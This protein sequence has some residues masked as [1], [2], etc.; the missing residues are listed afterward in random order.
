VPEAWPRVLV[1]EA[2][3]GG[4]RLRRAPGAGIEVAERL[5]QAQRRLAGDLQGLH[6][7]V[8]GLLAL[9]AE[10]VHQ[11]ALHVVH[12]AEALDALQGLQRL[13]RAVEVAGAAARP[14][15]QQRRDEAVGAARRHG[16]GEALG[17]GIVAGLQRLG[18]HEGADRARPLLQLRQPLGELERRGNVALRKLQQEGP[19][20]QLEVVGIGLQRGIDEL[21]RSRDVA[22][23]LRLQPGQVVAGEGGGLPADR[24]RH[25]GVR[26]LTVLRLRHRPGQGQRQGRHRR[27]TGEPQAAL[28]HLV[29][30]H[31]Q[32]S[33]PAPP[34]G[35]PVRRK[36]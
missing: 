29:H 16:A 14:R 21:H 3:V 23:G 8:L 6:Q 10:V 36:R 17:L 32:W 12:G 27:P 15:L 20:Q 1:E 25:L 34:S 11:A 22:Q 9:A 2:L 19:L 18:G 5:D 33:A 30:E 24:G 31:L 13:Q 28:Q 35:E 4:A 7:V 26:R